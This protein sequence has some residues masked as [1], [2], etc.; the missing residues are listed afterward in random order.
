MVFTVFSPSLKLAAWCLCGGKKFFFEH[1]PPQQMQQLHD[2]P[3][4]DLGRDQNI[5]CLLL[6]YINIIQNIREQTVTG[7]TAHSFPS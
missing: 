5:T 3:L 6:S 2:V 7:I 1:T 4:P